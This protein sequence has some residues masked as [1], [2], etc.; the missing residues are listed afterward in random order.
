MPLQILIVEDDLDLASTIMDYLSEQG[1]QMD[2]AANGLSGLNFLKSRRY[3]L[4]LLDVAMPKM[5]GLEMCQAIRH[6]GID[7]PV[8]MLTARDT[9]DDKLAGFDAGTDD[10]VVKPFEFAELIA[11][12]K[13]L[14]KRRSGQSNQLKVADLILDLDRRQA[15]RNNTP[16]QLSPI[17]WKILE[18]LIRHSPNVVSRQQLQDAVWGD[19]PP[20][21]NSLKVHLHRLRQDVDKPFNCAL[22]VTIPNH[23]IALR[24]PNED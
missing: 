22:I 16:L 8:L 24:D 17:G 3:D 12:I 19:D 23:G 20:D 4:I 15:N 21:S 9:L 2:Y 1:M 13:S 18:V 11:R 14:S 6:E 5:N 10:Y 7:T